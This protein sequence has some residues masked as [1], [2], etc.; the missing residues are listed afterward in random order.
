VDEKVGKNRQ[1]LDV[2]PLPD[3]DQDA[4][5]E[6]LL[7]LGATRAESGSG[8]ASRVELL[9]PAGNEFCVLSPR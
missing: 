4:E 7:A 3:G 8:D 2:A 6:R 5:V 1:H 9:D